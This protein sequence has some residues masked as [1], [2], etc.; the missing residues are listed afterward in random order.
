MNVGCIHVCWVR[1]VMWLISLDAVSHGLKIQGPSPVSIYL[2][3]QQEPGG[4]KHDYAE[5]NNRS[6][7][8]HLERPWERL[9]WF[10]LLL[11]KM[12]GR[13]GSPGGVEWRQSVWCLFRPSLKCVVIIG[14][15]FHRERGFKEINH[16][17]QKKKK[18]ERW[19]WENEKAMT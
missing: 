17:Q 15:W 4:T 12:R 8:F 3:P 18:K 14:F 7:E 5:V 13:N 2:K 9:Q 19:E 1:N 16:Y 10:Q 6:A 11:F